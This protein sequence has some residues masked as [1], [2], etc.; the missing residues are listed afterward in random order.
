MWFIE[1][2]G[3]QI[4]SH[5][6]ASQGAFCASFLCLSVCFFQVL[7]TLPKFENANQLLC[8]LQTSLDFFFLMV[9]P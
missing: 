2:Q 8:V 9:S 6:D 4:H 5:E 3:C 7:G 1:A